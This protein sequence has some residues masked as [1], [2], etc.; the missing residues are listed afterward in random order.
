MMEEPPGRKGDSDNADNADNMRAL[1]A[2][3]AARS[4][5]AGATA[6]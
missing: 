5:G 4:H 1:I 3:P 6:H 2:A